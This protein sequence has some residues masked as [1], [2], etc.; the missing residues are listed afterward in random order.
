MKS[1][2]HP[3]TREIKKT[4]WDERRGDG[5]KLLTR[6]EVES[7]IDQSLVF[8]PGLNGQGKSSE[9]LLGAKDE[10][11]KKERLAFLRK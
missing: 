5:T 3:E 9:K 11:R 10:P 2:G 1:S 6:S 8:R 7:V 4:G